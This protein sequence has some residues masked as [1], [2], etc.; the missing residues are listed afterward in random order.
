MKKNITN[1]GLFFRNLRKS[2][3]QTLE[4]AANELGVSISYIS[5]VEHGDRQLPKSWR[6][7]IISIYQLDDKEI[8]KLDESI[9]ATPRD[10]K[11]SYSDVERCFYN[12]VASFGFEGQEKEQAIKK[13]NEFL[14][15]I[16]KSS[17]SK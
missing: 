11:I 4:E 9:A 17:S 15:E 13:V 5:A 2:K 12:M 7:K 1:F 3:K 16:K 14:N 6:D 8:K 10:F